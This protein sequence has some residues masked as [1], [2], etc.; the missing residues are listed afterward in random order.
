PSRLEYHLGHETLAVSTGDHRR[1][2]VRPRMGPRLRLGVRGRLH[3]RLGAGLASR[4][5]DG[6]RLC[7]HPADRGTLVARD[8]PAVS[9]SAL[10]EWLKSSRRERTDNHPR[11]RGQLAPV[12]DD[13]LARIPDADRGTGVRERPC[14]ATPPDRDGAT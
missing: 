6:L 9:W 11:P 4:R 8:R 5:A 12:P 7:S 13:A 3:G 1:A 14:G 10:T 2:L